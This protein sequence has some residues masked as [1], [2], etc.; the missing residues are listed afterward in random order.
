M[1]RRALLH[2][3]LDLIIPVRKD[4]RVVYAG[5]FYVWTVDDLAVELN[6]RVIGIF[7]CG[8]V[9]FLDEALGLV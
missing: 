1:L 4:S 2:L 5:V 6:E 8:M 9:G 3:Q 7:C